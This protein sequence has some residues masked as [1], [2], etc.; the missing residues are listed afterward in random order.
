MKDKKTNKVFEIIGWII[1]AIFM[2]WALGVFAIGNPIGGIM[3]ALFALAVTPIRSKLLKFLKIE[4]SF[5][6]LALLIGVLFLVSCGTSIALT[7]TDSSQINETVVSIE[8]AT[9][10]DITDKE[11]EIAEMQVH[12]IDVEQGDATLVTC[13][14]E[15]MLID[16]GDN[17]KGTKIQ[18]YLLKQGV[19][20]L[21]YLVLTHPDADHIG[22]AD[23]IITKFDI[24]NVFMSDYTKDNQ[25]YNEMIQALDNKNY[26]WST[27]EVGSTY[28]LGSATFTIIAP[29]E[30]Y[31]DPNNASI[32]LLLQN[33]N[34]K[35]L[36]TGDAEEEAEA[37]ILANGISIACDVYKAGHHGSNTSNTKALLEAATPTYVVVSCGEGNSYGHPHAEPMNNF[38]SMGMKLFRTDE[39]GSVV[40]TTDGTEITWNCAPT[41]SWKAGESTESS[42]KGTA[43]KESTAASKPEEI[44]EPA[45]ESVTEEPVVEQPSQNEYVI[46][47][48]NTKA[49]HRPTCSRLPK[50]KNQVIFSS[51]EEALAAGYDNP[52][53]YC[54][55]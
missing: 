8:E 43:S 1:G 52:C 28:T 31:S 12:F 32:G 27:P 36:F 7:D 54:C 22:A 51:R 38:R 26:K 3:T 55:P 47:N 48:K 9:V 49:F 5:R 13:D 34:N 25:T 53:D 29:N 16:A 17:T 10:E 23:V 19:K 39:Q 4:L 42:T 40:A 44:S 33:G 6:T 41:E 37:D 14:G 24:E 46:G 18:S 11:N 45:T 21:K 2:L 15:A 30:K 50:E 20:N 35:F